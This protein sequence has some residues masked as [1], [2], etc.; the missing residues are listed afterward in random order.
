ML[1]LKVNHVSKRG[2]WTKWPQIRRRYFQMHFIEWKVLKFDYNFTEV[3]STG[4]NEQYPSIGL[5][6]GLAP[7]MRQAIMWSNAHPIHWRIHAA[8]EGDELKQRM[9]D[10]GPE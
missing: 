10:S 6:N 8:L 7:N 9:V 1:E 4:F 2:H 5:D 3:C